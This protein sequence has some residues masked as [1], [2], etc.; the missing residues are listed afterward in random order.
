MSAADLLRQALADAPDGLRV[1]RD[2]VAGL[3]GLNADDYDTFTAGDW[4]ATMRLIGLLLAAAP[5]LAAAVASHPACDPGIG[6][7]I[8]EIRDA[9]TEAAQAMEAES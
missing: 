2:D 7:S 9:I 3:L 5:E 8:A 1:D 6:C 4:Q